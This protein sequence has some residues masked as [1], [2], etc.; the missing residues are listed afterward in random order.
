MIKHFNS[1]ERSFIKPRHLHHTYKQMSVSNLKGFLEL[2]KSRPVSSLFTT[3]SPSLNQIKIV[4]GNESAD[5]DSVSSALSYAYFDYL[6][7]EQSQN[8]KTV[9]PLVPIINIPRED[10]KLRKDIV[11]MLT[12]QYSITED[13]LY[14]R[15]DLIKWRAENQGRLT[16]DSIL[17]DHN[18]LVN[19]SLDLIDNV[20]G[21][22]DHHED[23]GKY[24]DAIPRIITVTGSCTSLVYNYWAGKL[25]D[26]GAIKDV[27]P[28]LYG[29]ALLDTA[30]FKHKVEDPD[31]IALANYKLFGTGNNNEVDA[32]D[33]NK[34]D[35]YQE[36]LFKDLKK[37]KK[38]I[39]GLSVRDVIR[40]DYKQF[41]FPIGDNKDGKILTVGIGSMVKSLK[42]LYK[43]YKG[44]DNFHAECERF[45][46]EFQL[47]LVVVMSSFNNK[48]NNNEF[49]REMVLVSSKPCE[50]ITSEL[51]AGM[52]PI[53]QLSPRRGK[54]TAQLA[55][56]CWQF[57][58]RNVEASRKQV[59]PYM[60][61]VLS[62]LSL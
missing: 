62:S 36:T 55:P 42:W 2:L 8:S 15:E 4:C 39:K 50:Q 29:A 33:V 1:F 25:R 30:N 19:D 32:M 56:N 14:F 35:Q 24:Q 46:E 51:V 7:Q 47:D 17:V 18:E 27:I 13:L 45:R 20:S 9:I 40:K 26:Q 37:A 38:D 60:K 53:L 11:Y 21:I 12:N 44:Q 41:E 34:V 54:D 23:I 22:I 57:D 58:Q 3:V 59:V 61:Q 31:R 49:T 10:L 28:L 6:Y 43:E 48:D 52:T 16:I 5:F